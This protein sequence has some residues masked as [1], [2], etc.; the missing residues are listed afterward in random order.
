MN[1]FKKLVM[2][3]FYVKSSFQHRRGEACPYGFVGE[4]R[5]ER[6]HESRP[7]GSFVCGCA[8]AGTAYAAA[9][10]L[11]IPVWAADK[12]SPEFIPPEVTLS[13]AGQSAPAQ[14]NAAPGLPADAG[15]NTGG[16]LSR[17]Y[18]GADN[19]AMNQLNANAGGNRQL[20]TPNAG[21]TQPG[22]GNAQANT[23]GVP[24]GENTGGASPAPTSTDNKPD[25]IAT[26][27]TDKGN[28]VIRLF[29][30]YAPKTTANFIDLAGKGVYNGLTFHRVE[31][32]FCIQ[33]GDPR[34]DGFGVYY[35]PGTQQPRILPL[36]TNPY[37]KHNAPGVVAMA[38]FPKNPN[39]ASCQFYITLA[40]EPQLDGDYSIFGGV[41]QGMDVVNKIA[42]GDKM[43]RVYVQEQQ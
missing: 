37:L 6:A 16:A 22:T 36:E 18:A 41:I 21:A 23:A 8:K 38:H 14:P 31:P 43:N 11:L 40:P 28:I 17:P 2:L 24:A 10:F 4:R 1:Y 25:P 42:K 27:E 19:P 29:R 15:E 30:Q 35:E 33:G 3:I 26:I 39:T 13:G 20:M 9:I 5:F 32:G 7:Y 12:I 34:G